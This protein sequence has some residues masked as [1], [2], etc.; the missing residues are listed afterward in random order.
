MEEILYDFMGHAK[1]CFEH[2]V[3]F[4]RD[5]DPD[6]FERMFRESFWEQRRLREESEDA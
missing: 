5:S 6:T 3:K 4:D 2:T 1:K